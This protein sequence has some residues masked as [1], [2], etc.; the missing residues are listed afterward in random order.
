MLGQ[1]LVEFGIARLK[2]G[3][4]G[5]YKAC[6]FYKGTHFHD[7]SSEILTKYPLFEFFEGCAYCKIQRLQQCVMFL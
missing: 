3:L 1:I 6:W 4:K 7:T 2:L 5:L